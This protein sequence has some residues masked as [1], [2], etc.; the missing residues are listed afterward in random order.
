MHILINKTW[1]RWSTHLV[2]KFNLSLW[3]TVIRRDI[4]FSL[5]WFYLYLMSW[6]ILKSLIMGL[7]R[8]KEILYNL[9]IWNND[10]SQMLQCMILT[11]L[12]ITKGKIFYIQ[13]EFVNLKTAKNKQLIAFI[14]IICLRNVFLVW[15]E[16][17]N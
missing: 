16:L 10:Y 5:I 4:R 2:I 6:S 3:N 13:G 17:E 8:I 7:L 14:Y 11:T 9:Q 1:D 15:R 12:E